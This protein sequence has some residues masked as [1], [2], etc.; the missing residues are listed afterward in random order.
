MVKKL[1]NLNLFSAILI[2]HKLRFF[3]DFINS[4]LKKGQLTQNCQKNW[5]NNIFL[6]FRIFLRITSSK[7]C[8]LLWYLF[9]YRKPFRWSYIKWISL[10]VNMKPKYLKNFNWN[11]VKNGSTFAG[12]VFGHPV[13]LEFAMMLS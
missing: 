8:P 4:F 3:N 12:S 2:L 10:M 5:E 9:L 1:K 6:N 13:L 11:I 7:V